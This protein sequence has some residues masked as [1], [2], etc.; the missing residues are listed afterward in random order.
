MT[1]VAFYGGSFNP[2]HNAHRL[3]GL[4]LA[5]LA[6]F[7]R[8]LVVVCFQQSGKDLAPFDDRFEMARR[9][10]AGH[11]KIEVSAIERDLGGESL[12]LRTLR[13]LRELHPDW[14]LR[15]AAGGDIVESKERWG[16][17]WAHVERLAPPY[18]V[19][20]VGYSAAEG[21]PFLPDI[22]S[23][24]LRKLLAAGDVNAARAYLPDPVADYI[25]GSRLYLAA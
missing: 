16:D 7:E 25:E 15:F 24:T 19:P 11:P 2:L 21:V 3:F 14:R 22:C 9:A 5:E 10:F 18:F 17:D 6:E 1:N 20:R 23:T 8:V 12:T 13:V 4:H